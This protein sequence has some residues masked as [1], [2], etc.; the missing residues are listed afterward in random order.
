M[1]KD[2]K[3]QIPISFLRLKSFPLTCNYSSVYKK[4]I[5]LAFTEEH[6]LGIK[7]IKVSPQKPM[8]IHEKHYF[9]SGKKLSIAYFF[10]EILIKPNRTTTFCNSEY[11]IT[12]VF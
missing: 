11:F 10:S 12:F 3:T 2:T 6:F 7:I 1:S 9:H 8:R 5:E 4:P